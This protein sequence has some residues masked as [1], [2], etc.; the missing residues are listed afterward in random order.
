MEKSE[1]PNGVSTID[2]VAD[3]MMVAY[4][5]QTKRLNYSFFNSAVNA[6]NSEHFFTEATKNKCAFASFDTIYYLAVKYPKYIKRTF[7]LSSDDFKKDSR[8]WQKGQYFHMYAVIE[9]KDGFWYAASP[10]NHET[11]EKNSYALEMI[12]EESLQKIL[13]KIKN[14]DGGNWPTVS[15][16]KEALNGGLYRQPSAIVKENVLKV[17]EIKYD[18]RDDIGEMVSRKSGIIFV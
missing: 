18:T 6:D 15:Q 11:D 17:F 5:Q 1:I 8:I 3:A 10:A 16:I 12:R 2:A 4:A 7:L 9:G 13:D 14:R